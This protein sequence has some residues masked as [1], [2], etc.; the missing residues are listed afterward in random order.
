ILW[1]RAAGILATTVIVLIVLGCMSISIGGSGDQAS[2]TEEGCLVQ[3][4]E[5]TVQSGCEIKVYYPI[6]YVHVP[7]LEVSS[8]FD[9][10]EVVSQHEDYFRIR[11]SSSFSR[12]AHWKARGERANPCGSPPPL[13]GPHIAPTPTGTAEPD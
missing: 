12:T 7:N 9:E 5:V 10:M 2:C 4:G 1:S 8:T 13:A 11:N 3:K 6:T